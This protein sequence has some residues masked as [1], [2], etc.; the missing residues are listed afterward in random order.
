[1]GAEG[2]DEANG[3]KSREIRSHL[4]QDAIE[5]YDTKS[6]GEIEEVMWRLCKTQCVEWE[7]AK[8]S[9]MCW[10]RTK[11]QMERGP[12]VR[13]PCCCCLFI[14]YALLLEYDRT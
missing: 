6:E 9:W 12:D 3:S 1:M 5:G 10:M 8:M 4:E 13:N 11:E 14:L 7:C 2:L